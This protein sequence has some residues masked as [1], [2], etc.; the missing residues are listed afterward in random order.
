MCVV[1]LSHSMGVPGSVV[2]VSMH[3]DEPAGSK[4]YPLAGLIFSGFGTMATTNR[5]P[6]T[7]SADLYWPKEVKN[8]VMLGPVESQM[9][10]GFLQRMADENT[11]D[12]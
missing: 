10:E 1:L 7:G 4:S 9:S 8:D 12:G 5:A 2:A 11:S 6:T 3:A